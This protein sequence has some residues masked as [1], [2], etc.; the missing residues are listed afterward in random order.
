MAVNLRA[1]IGKLNA[2][3]RSAV[4]GAAGLCLSRTHYDVEIE[5]FLMKPLDATDG[6]LRAILKHYGIDRSRSSPTNS[7]AAST[8]SR[9]ATRARRPQPDARQGADR[10]VDASARSSTARRRCAPAH[11]CSRC[12]RTTSS[13]GWRRTSAASS[14]R[15]RPR[16][17]QKDFGDGHGRR[18]SEAPAKSRRCPAGARATP[19]TG[20]PSTAAA[21]RRTST[22]S[23]SNLTARAKAGKIDPVLGRDFEIRQVV[24]I[25][26]RR[27]QNNPI[28]TG[29][30]GVGKTAVVEGFAL[31]IVAEGDV[32]RRRS[33]TSRSARS[34]SGCCRPAP[35]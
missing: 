11:C 19:S 9:R 18:R 31:R 23:R 7:R 25:L 1:L 6:D 22:S 34:T 14:R 28:L 32:P 2:A 26:T 4:E 16:S 21:R 10:G 20:T 27:R 35:A 5:H 8:S 3:C 13:R 30:A 33:R 15:S 17:L 12:S 29:E 24:D